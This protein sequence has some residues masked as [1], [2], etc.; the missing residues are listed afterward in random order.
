MLLARVQDRDSS[1]R[2]RAYALRLLPSAP[3]PAQD[4]ISLVRKFPKGLTIELLEELLQVNDATLSLEVV[5]TLA[6]NAPASQALLTAIA[7]DPDRDENLRA[8]AVAG[9]A[10]VAEQHL[11]LLFQLAADIQRSVR[12][13][14]LRCLRL[15]HLSDQQ[16]AGLRQIETQYPESADLI[17]AVLD[18]SS[19]K[20]DRPPVTD[21]QA[22][23]QL[24]EKIESPADPN[25][26]RRLFHHTRVTSCANCH[27]HDGRGNVVGPDLTSLGKRNDDAWLLKSILTPS[28]DMAP[29]FQPRTIVL[30]DGRSFTGIRLRSYTKEQIRDANGLTQTFE[31]GDVEA[32]VDSHVSFMPNGLADTLTNRELRDLIAF[33]QNRPDDRVA[34]HEPSSSVAEPLVRVVDLDVGET[35]PSN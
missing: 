7:V 33:L 19:L 34:G 35:R 15:Q 18:P 9:L 30:K 26:G 10:A 24:L 14:A 28:A 2:L 21:T 11:D 23:L 29:E 4:G 27:R 20:T 8:E 32:I 3:Q 13:E 22:W 17:Q 6:A 5:R 25:S 1:P 16:I 12:E 31:K